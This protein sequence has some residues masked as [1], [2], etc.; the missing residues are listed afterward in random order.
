MA[1][2]RRTRVPALTVREEFGGD[3]RTE[4]EAKLASS[5]NPPNA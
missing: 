5:A 2:P 1:M 4:V 3:Q